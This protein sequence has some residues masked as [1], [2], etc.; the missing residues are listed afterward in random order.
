[1]QSYVMCHLVEGTHLYLV[2][3]SEKK[4][5]CETKKETI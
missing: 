3:E 5:D 2:S 4:N 1:M